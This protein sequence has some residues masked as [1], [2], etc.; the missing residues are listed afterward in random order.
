MQTFLNSPFVHKYKDMSVKDL[1]KRLKQLKFKCDDINE[2]KYVFRLLRDY[3]TTGKTP[4][5]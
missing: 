3:A 1:K 2:F 5:V 4:I